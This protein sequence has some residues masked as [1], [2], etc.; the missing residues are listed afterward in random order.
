MLVAGAGWYEFTAADREQITA[1]DRCNEIYPPNA[2]ADLI[3]PPSYA[4]NPQSGAVTELVNGQWQLVPESRLARDYQ[5]GALAVYGGDGKWHALLKAGCT[6]PFVGYTDLAD[7]QRM[8]APARA[9][10]RQTREDDIR[11]FTVAALII[12]AGGSAGLLVLGLVLG[13]IIRGFRGEL[14]PGT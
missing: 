14:T 1:L 12:G 2:F 7:F 6:G 8:Q 4:L 5:T 9:A 11:F 10:L 13:W 3:P